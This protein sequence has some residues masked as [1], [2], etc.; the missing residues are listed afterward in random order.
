VIRT[1]KSFREFLA[2]EKTLG[3]I[4]CW[5]SAIF[6]IIGGWSGTASKN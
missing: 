1:D 5:A 2:K 3:K 6:G 4:R